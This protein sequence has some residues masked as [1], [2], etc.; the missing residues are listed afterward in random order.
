MLHSF[1]SEA[2]HA[3]TGVPQLILGPG[4]EQISN[5]QEPWNFKVPPA[6]PPPSQN[7]V[8]IVLNSALLA[9]YFGMGVV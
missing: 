8:Q 3:F 1:F 2:P 4:T 7:E 9:P 6:I 5:A